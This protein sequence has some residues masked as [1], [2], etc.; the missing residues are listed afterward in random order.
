MSKRMK[1][2][3]LTE[4][5]KKLLEDISLT[6]NDLASSLNCGEISVSRWRKKLGIKVPIGS[7]KHKSRPWQS[8]KIERCCPIC[9]MKFVTTPSNKKRYCSKKCS[10]KDIDRSYMNSEKYKDSLR[11]ET[12][13]EYKRYSNLVHKLSHR[14]Y[15]IYKEEINPNNFVRG[16]AG[17][18]DAYHL[19]HIISVKFGFDNNISPEE[20]SRK[21][22]LQMLPWKDNII[23]GK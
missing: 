21:E 1:F 16:L 2:S 8:K 17:E 13:E 14:T 19:D 11:K 10:S 23:K 22:N 12:T 7:K 5:Q 3:E 20:M 15:E 9:D 6:R 18:I 4:N